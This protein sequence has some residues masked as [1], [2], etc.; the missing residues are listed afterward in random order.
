MLGMNRRF[1]AK[2]VVIVSLCSGY[3]V[4]LLATVAFN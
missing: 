3:R 1:N 2:G 4:A